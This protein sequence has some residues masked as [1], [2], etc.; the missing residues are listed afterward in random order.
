MKKISLFLALILG[1]TQVQAQFKKIFNGK[2]LSGWTAHG[3]E[4]WYVEEGNMICESGPD[5]QYGYLSTDQAYKNF[6]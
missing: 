3:T 1:F 6:I 5:K 4:K 2:D